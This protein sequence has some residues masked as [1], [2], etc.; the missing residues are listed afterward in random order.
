VKFVQICCPETSGPK[1][2]QPPQLPGGLHVKASHNVVVAAEF[3][4]KN[5][6]PVSDLH[7]W[8]S[9][10]QDNIDPAALFTLTIWSDVPRQTNGAIVTPGHPGVVLWTE[11]FGPGEYYQCLYSKV[12]EQFY[13]PSIPAIVR[14]DGKLYYLCFYPKNPF[15]QEGT[16]EWPTNYW[17]SV[18]TQTTDGAQLL[19]GWHTSTDSDNYPAVQGNAPFPVAWNT[20]IDS[21]GAPLTLAFKVTTPANNP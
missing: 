14:G 21:Q 2:L 8:G 20:L 1:F 19:F 17:L 11:P 16:A 9:W 18:S 12:T 6:G 10:L 4:C 15:V 7:L 3:V 5:T 13:D